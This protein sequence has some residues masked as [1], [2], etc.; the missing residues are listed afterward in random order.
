MCFGAS[1]VAQW[2]GTRLPTQGTRVRALV[3]EDPTC[4]GA[5]KP[6]SHNYWACALGPVSHNHWACVPHLPK[7][8]CLEPVLRD[9][10]PPQ[11]EARAPQWRVAPARRN[12]RKPARSNEDPAKPKINKINK[13]FKKK[14]VLPFCQV[15][16]PNIRR[17]LAWSRAATLC[18]W[19]L[20]V[21]ACALVMMPSTPETLVRFDHSNAHSLAQRAV[22]TV[23]A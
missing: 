11:W 7:P 1:L 21:E 6:V 16:F 23:G 8:V 15:F 2:L 20:R 17:K 13:F 14:C 5:A 9:E 18:Y 12:Y 4:R 19:T 3:W 10:K 22:Y